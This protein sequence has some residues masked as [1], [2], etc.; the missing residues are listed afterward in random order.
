MRGRGVELGRVV[1]IG[2]RGIM[3]ASATASEIASGIASE[4]VGH[5][6]ARSCK[7]H[8]PVRSLSNKPC[9]NF[10]KDVLIR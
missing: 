4:R 5:R 8:P 9:H 10:E 3:G 1:R 7:L 2:T 6:E